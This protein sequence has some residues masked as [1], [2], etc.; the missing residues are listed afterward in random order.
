MKGHHEKSRYKNDIAN[1]FIIRQSQDFRKN[2][3]KALTPYEEYL[4][5]YNNISCG[6]KTILETMS[7]AELFDFLNIVLKSSLHD[8]ESLKRENNSLVK[9]TKSLELIIQ[10]TEIQNRNLKMK[11][12]SLEKRR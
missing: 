9:E 1:K 11:L 5:E 2:L 3:I 12:E 8:K 4:K 7:I 10:D 6:R